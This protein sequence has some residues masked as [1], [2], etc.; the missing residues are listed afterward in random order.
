MT[1]GPFESAEFKYIYS[2]FLKKVFAEGKFK[3]FWE[4]KSFKEMLKEEKTG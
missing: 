3:N 4:E 1:K 2:D